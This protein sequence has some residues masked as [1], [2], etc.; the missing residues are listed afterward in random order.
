MKHWLENPTNERPLIPNS[1]YRLGRLALRSYLGQPQRKV[2]LKWSSI[3]LFHQ[4]SEGARDP[5]RPQEWPTLQHQM[6][7]RVPMFSDSARVFLHG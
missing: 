2:I 1:T 3:S 6:W 4:V 5:K 7:A